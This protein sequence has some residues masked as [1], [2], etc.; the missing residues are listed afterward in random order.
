[1]EFMQMYEIKRNQGK[2][3]RA[4]ANAPSILASAVPMISSTLTKSKM[5]RS[6]RMRVLFSLLS[7]DNCALRVIENGQP[8]AY[9]F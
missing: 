6:P 9:K 2:P 8:S 3:C 5:A 1:M 4:A 7:L